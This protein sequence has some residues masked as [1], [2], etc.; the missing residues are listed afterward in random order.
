MPGGWGARACL[1]TRRAFH[2]AQRRTGSL[3]GRSGGGRQAA[4]P[5]Q[6]HRPRGVGGSAR[7]A[8]LGSYTRRGWNANRF[9]INSLFVSSRVPSPGAGC[10]G[11]GRGEI[12]LHCAGTHTH[13]WR[14]TTPRECRFLHNCSITCPIRMQFTWGACPVRRSTHLQSYVINLYVG[15]TCGA[16]SA[17]GRIGI[18]FAVP[19]PLRQELW[20]QLAHEESAV[21]AADAVGRCAPT[22]RVGYRR[23]AEISVADRGHLFVSPFAKKEVLLVF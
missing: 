9:F 17:K 13:C 21:A 10:G 12:G 14:G 15:M 7:A 20:Y 3:Q 1:L 18:R 19:L 4:G 8:L 11:Q 2:G 6:G 22:V 16:H 5:A 23:L